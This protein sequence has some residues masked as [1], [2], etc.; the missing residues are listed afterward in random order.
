MN[1]NNIHKQVHQ[2]N[3]LFG[4]IIN[5]YYPLQESININ[6]FDVNSIEFNRSQFILR[7]KLIN[8]EIEETINAINNDDCIEIIDGLCDMLYV[9][10]GAIVYFNLPIT[11]INNEISTM[12]NLDELNTLIDDNYILKIL[13]DNIEISENIE[14]IIKDNQLLSELTT[15]ILEDSNYYDDY[16]YNYQSLINNI[17]VNVY[18]ISKLLNININYFFNIVH[19][20]NMSKVCISEEEALQTIEWYKN[21]E[22]RYKSPSYRETSYNGIIYYIIYDKDTGKILKS[23]NY[24]KVIFM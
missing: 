4:V 2:F 17:I 12:T 9:L 6:L 16:I 23:I 19:N 24:V 10:F 1:C 8:E 13:K 11:F 15:K 20:S 5:E 14:L 21:N 22:H 7:Y 18:K 3:Y